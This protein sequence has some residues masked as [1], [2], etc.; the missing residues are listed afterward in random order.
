MDDLESVSGGV[1][2]KQVGKA[3]DR[4]NSGVQQVNEFFEVV[5]GILSFL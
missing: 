2:R 3:L 5:E 4:F 1:S